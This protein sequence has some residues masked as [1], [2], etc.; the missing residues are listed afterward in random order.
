MNFIP[1]LHILLP[2][3]VEGRYSLNVLL[4][5]STDIGPILVK[6]EAQPQPP[7]ALE[8]L[9]RSIEPPLSPVCPVTITSV[10][11]LTTE[12][13]SRVTAGDISPVTI[14]CTNSSVAISHATTS[15]PAMAT[16]SHPVTNNLPPVTTPPLMS[17]TT[18]CSVPST[19]PLFTTPPPILHHQS[20]VP[21]KK[22]M[23][24]MREKKHT[25]E[26][27][28]ITL[29]PGTRHLCKVVS[30]SATSCLFYAALLENEEMTKVG[31]LLLHIHH[32]IVYIVP[33]LFNPFF[34]NQYS[35][36]I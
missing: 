28:Q 6:Q 25:S 27:P 24:G 31:W 32:C 17:T 33:L 34:Y 1:P 22:E 21:W 3:L 18:H 15:F 2:T 35:C 13:S 23:S 12:T 14:T 10:H 19:F 8:V 29:H 36:P 4:F 20:G 5:S 7:P 11:P 30:V 9:C 16:N 26:V